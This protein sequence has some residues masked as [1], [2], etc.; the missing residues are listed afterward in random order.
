MKDKRTVRK[1]RFYIALGA[2]TVAVITSFAADDV[3]ILKLRK[4]LEVELNQRAPMSKETAA[5]IRKLIASLAK[6]DGPDYGLS[7]TLSG[8]SFAPIPGH[9]H[10]GALLLTDHQIKPSNSLKELVEIGPAALPFLL[11]A[12][13]DKTPTKFTLEHKS[14]IGGMWFANELRGNPLNPVEQRALKVKKKQ[15]KD[16]FPEK[17]VRSYTLKV[18]DVCLVA[19]GQIVGRGYQAVRYQPTACIVINS[20]TEDVN[21]R[22]QVRTIW[23]SKD[24][25]QHLFK[26]LLLDYASEGIWKER[27]SFDTWSVG[28]NLQVEAAMRL[29][30]YFPKETAALI[31]KRVQGLRVDRQAELDAWARREAANGIRTDEFIKAV[32]WCKEPAVR[33]AVRTVAKRTDDSSIFLATLPALDGAPE[34]MIRGRIEFFLDKLPKDEG[35]AY[36]EGY[37]LLGASFQWA[38]KTTEEIFAGYMRDATP[39]RCYTACLVLQQQKT[40]PQWFTPVLIRLLEDKRAVPGYRHPLAAKSENS[41]P[42]RV[43][44]AAAEALSKSQKNV[45]FTMIGTDEELDQQITAI[46]E[47]LRRKNK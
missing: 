26:S 16:G 9:S 38:P 43:C 2:F 37:K 17:Q 20:A 31:G 4:Q 10:A 19:I 12:L 15:E 1:H 44:D 32:A 23:S 34:K 35:G 18:G 30:Y 6:I 42:I 7:A 29:L 47:K 13:E 46:K 36:G 24:P 39:Q 22:N 11:D 8:T 41:T 5:R 33:D 14:I 27:E 3:P 25:M 28:S 21:L 40:T 45:R